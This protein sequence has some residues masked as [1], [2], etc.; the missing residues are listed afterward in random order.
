MKIAII[1]AIAEGRVI[2]YG[3]AL[4]WHLNA[5]LKHF[6]ALTMGQ[7]IIMGRKTHESIGRA[8]PGRMNIVVTRQTDYKI[9]KCTVSHSL[10]EAFVVAERESNTAFVIGGAELYAQ[11]LPRADCIYVTEIHSQFKG[12][13]YFPDFDRNQWREVSREEGVVDENNPYAH[14]F[15]TLVRERA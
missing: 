13:T 14:T 6:K 2:G 10:D 11:T 9:P 1:V 12:D 5:D 8:L 7:P 4:P 3:N 15:V